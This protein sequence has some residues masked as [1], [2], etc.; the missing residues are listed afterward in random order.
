ML[1]RSLT[2]T[3]IMTETLFYLESHK[4]NAGKT[5]YGEYV[6]REMLIGCVRNFLVLRIC[7]E[8]DMGHVS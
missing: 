1:S 4:N 5:L 3:S 8:V 6:W 2:V 7:Y